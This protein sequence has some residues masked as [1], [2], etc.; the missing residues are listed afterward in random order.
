MKL[1]GADGKAELF[2]ILTGEPGEWRRSREKGGWTL[3]EKRSFSA[4]RAAESPVH[5]HGSRA[6]NRNFRTSDVKAQRNSNFREKDSAPGPER[7]HC[8]ARSFP[9]KNLSAFASVSSGV[10][11]SSC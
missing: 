6:G 8:L 3:T 9:A 4:H 5:I 10:I 11:C 1:S 2:R 7:R